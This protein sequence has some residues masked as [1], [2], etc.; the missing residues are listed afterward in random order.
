MRNRMR[1][2]A[3]EF[4]LV[5]AAV[6]ASH[7]PSGKS[8]AGFGKPP[9]GFN[10][11]N[12]R[13]ALGLSNWS[14]CSGNQRLFEATAAA[15]KSTGLQ[16]LGYVYINTDD[17]WMNHDRSHGV[18]KG[19]QVPQSELWR[20]PEWQGMIDKLHADGFRFG[21]YTAMGN[22]SC[23]KVSTNPDISALRA[24][25]DCNCFLTHPLCL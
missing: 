19:T 7:L 23:C 18:G 14:C 21:L 9:L 11:C 24:V 4:S 22:Q 5:L 10:N 8:T 16:R 12:V 13:T 25:T 3:R 6:V 20:F 15:L 2:V 17:G 1:D